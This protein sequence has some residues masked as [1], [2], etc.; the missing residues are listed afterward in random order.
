MLHRKTFAS[1]SDAKVFLCNKFAKFTSPFMKQIL[2]GIVEN[3]RK[4]LFMKEQTNLWN[5]IVGENIRKLRE[6]NN[7]TQAMLGEFLGY[8]A[9]TVANYESGYRLPDLVTA[10]VIAKHYHVLLDELME[11]HHE[12]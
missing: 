8:G 9:T 7:E 3:G 1:K 10:Y 4:D 2:K 12:S 6:E 11:E 5:K